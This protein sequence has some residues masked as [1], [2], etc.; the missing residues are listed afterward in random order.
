MSKYAMSKRRL[1]GLERLQESEEVANGIV[2]ATGWVR[3]KQATQSGSQALSGF[4]VR[5][6]T[7]FQNGK[8]RPGRSHHIRG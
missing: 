8:E 5:L 2:L 3:S 1:Q 7:V 6:L 4:R